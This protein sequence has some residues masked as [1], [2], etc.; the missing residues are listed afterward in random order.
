MEVRSK[1]Q[2]NVEISETMYGMDGD[3]VEKGCGEW[4]VG[5]C[6]QREI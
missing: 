1:W 2:Q 5:G 3:D 6:R 4:M